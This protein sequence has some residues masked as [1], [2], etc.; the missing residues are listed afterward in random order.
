MSS[1]KSM[2]GH[3]MG[4]SS[5][6]ATVACSLAIQRNFIPPTINYEEFDPDC[7]LDCVKDGAREVKHKIIISNAYAFGGNTSSLILSKLN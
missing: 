7:D 2:T 4:A 3:T 5:G 6:I 1:I